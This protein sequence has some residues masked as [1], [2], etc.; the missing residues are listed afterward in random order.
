VRVLTADKYIN[1]EMVREI[2]AGGMDNIRW[3]L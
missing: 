3:F 1:K 2:H